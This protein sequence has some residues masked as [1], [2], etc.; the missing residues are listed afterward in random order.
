MT[1]VRRLL[2]GLALLLSIGIA[3]SIFAGETNIVTLRLKNGDSLTGEV[4]SEDD[5]RI[6]LSTPWNV[7]IFVPKSA[8]QEQLVITPQPT[9]LPS[10]SGQPSS[11]RLSP[12]TESTSSATSDTVLLSTDAPVALTQTIRQNSPTT[13]AEEPSHWKWNLKMGTDFL[14][15]AKDRQ[16]YSA[17]TGLTYTRNY[18]SDPKKFLRNK[19]EYTLQYGETDGDV[20]ANAMAGANKLDVDIFGKFYGYAAVGAGYDAVRKIKYQYELGPGLGYHLLAEDSLVMDV[21]LGLNYQYRQGSD[22]AP[23]RRV[24]Q[25]RIGQELTWEVASKITLTES[26]AFLPILDESRQYQFRVGGNLGFG[27]M[28][29]LSLNLTVLNFYDTQPAPEVPNNEFQFRSSLGV[30]F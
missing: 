18:K 23:N 16:I 7:A 25:G 20:S 29:H 21:E 1:K 8:I 12:G 22:G 5:E 6:V 11:D 10:E 28:R 17:S 9:T 3:Q 2:A 19:I 24:V 27:I 13:E 14:V 4:L 15:G 30:N 26:A